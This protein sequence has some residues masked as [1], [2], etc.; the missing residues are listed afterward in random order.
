MKVEKDV[1]LSCGPMLT[2]S[3]AHLP[4]LL[5]LVISGPHDMIAGG[6]HAGLMFISKHNSMSSAL[7]Q[8]YI[9]H[10]R[11]CSLCLCLHRAEFRRVVSPGSLHMSAE[12]VCYRAFRPKIIG[13]TPCIAEHP[14]SRQLKFGRTLCSSNIWSS[15]SGCEAF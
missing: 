5:G 10:E 14:H 11:S 4:D 8:Q 1:W 12:R 6:V 15:M 13:L 3:H 7:E 2:R 9:R